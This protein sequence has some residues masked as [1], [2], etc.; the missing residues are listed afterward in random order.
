MKR[1]FQ[2][3]F[4]KQKNKVL[5]I[6]IMFILI[7]LFSFLNPL[8][9]K[10][11]MDE[12]MT[13]KNFKI[14]WISALILLLMTLLQQV[15][16]LIQARLSTSIKNEFILELL[17]KTFRK[18]TK[19]K[20]EY[21]NKNNSA[22][23][24]SRLTYDTEITGWIVD[25]NMFSSIS[26]IVGII[27]GTAGLIFVSGKLTILVFLF[28]PLKLYLVYGISKKN[29]IVEQKVISE[30]SIFNAWFGNIIN[31]I[32]EIKLWNLYS[33]KQLECEKR[34]RKVLRLTRE[35]DMLNN[36]N[37]SGDI[38]L[39]ELLLVS[40][41]IA[42]GWMVGHEELTIGGLI[43]F[44]SYSV[45]ITGP[46]SSIMNLKYL[47]ST[48]KPSLER[49]DD[50]FGLEEEA[51]AKETMSIEGFQSI[52]MKNVSYAYD[53]KNV[54]NK[55]N[56]KINKGDKIA[57][58]GDNGSGKTTLINLLLRFMKPTSGEILFNGKD[59][60]NLEVDAYREWFSV[61]DQST[62]IY[63]DTVM[64]NINL[65]KKVKYEKVVSICKENDVDALINGLADGYDTILDE[66]AQNLSGGERQ[67]L[68]FAR[69][70]VKDSEILI[71]DEPTSNYDLRSMQE[72]LK[73]ILDE[74]ERKTIIIITHDDRISDRI[75][76]VYT[77]KDGSC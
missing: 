65:Q 9:I 23:I 41:Y 34:K 27:S 1:I 63:S 54:L 36:Y 58:V 74:H 42:G 50:F 47:Y 21:F 60:N 8:I 71:L 25:H 3:V 17:L 13:E 5:I 56:L 72:W 35:S 68:A 28:I 61:V 75:E 24:L 10:N 51:T 33:D 59:I 2:D 48:I 12:G 70:L 64:N 67:K 14:V 66:D 49:L 46:I 16:V 55:V 26:N 18:L 69:A 30:T 11:L 29:E 15:A 31:G 20:M 57:I 39:T 38:I 7:S 32:K 43:A 73:R 52:E 22:E 4:D 45:A 62:Y 6:V 19:L 53:E 77:L 37:M 44:I 76:K 40:L